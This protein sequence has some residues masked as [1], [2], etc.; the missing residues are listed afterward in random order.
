MLP[1]LSG[2]LYSALV[3][4]HTSIR[5]VLPTAY[6]VKYRSI[7]LD[8]SAHQDSIAVYEPAPFPNPKSEPSA[9]CVDVAS[10]PFC[11]LQLLLRLLLLQRSGEVAISTKETATPSQHL[12]LH[13][14]HLRPVVVMIQANIL[15]KDYD[16]ASGHS[17]SR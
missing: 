10:F 15:V 9:S 6:N 3:L 8:R 12:L 4:P 1:R 2:T 16:D 13:Y 11:Q 14:W 7:P 17:S 5:T